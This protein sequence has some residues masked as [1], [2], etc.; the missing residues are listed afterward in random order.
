MHV[1]FMTQT[2]RHVF[3]FEFLHT[4]TTRITIINYN[5]CYLNL[6]NYRFQ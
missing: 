2:I 1:I 5:S 3:L 6:I 4:Q